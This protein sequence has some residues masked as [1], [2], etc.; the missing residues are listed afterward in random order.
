MT[1]LDWHRMLL[2]VAKELGTTTD[3]LLEMKVA[4]V[5]ELLRAHAEKTGEPSGGYKAK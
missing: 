5:A 2:R 4:E 3:V 1:W